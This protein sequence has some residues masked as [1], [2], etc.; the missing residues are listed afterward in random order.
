MKKRLCLRGILLGLLLCPVMIQPLHAEE[1]A[2]TSKANETEHKAETKVQ[3]TLDILLSAIE[4]D[5]Y[6]AFSLAVDDEMKSAITKDVF[7]NVV[8]QIAPQLKAGY[9]Q[10]YFGDMKKRGYRTHLWKLEFQDNADD[11]LVEL[12]IK[13]DKV[14]GFLLR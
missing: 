11:F 9:T 10:T 13:D 4:A 12:S 5:D 6:A 8:K 3:N 14:G 7:E 1:V 2:Q